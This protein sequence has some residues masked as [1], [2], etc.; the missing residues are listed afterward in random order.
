VEKSKLAGIAGGIV[1]VIIALLLIQYQSTTTPTQSVSKPTETKIKIIAS[2]YPLY[3]FATN[4]G[5]DKAKI[6]SFVPIGIEPHD[7]EPSTG[8][9]L[10]LKNTQLFVYNGAGMEP[11]VE[12]LINSEEYTNVKFVETAKGITLIESDN[13]HEDDDTHKSL[14]NPH[15]WLDPIL[16]KH[17]V[18]IIKDAIIESD[19]Q[20]KQ[21]YEDNANRY[22][23]KLENLDLKIKS[24]LSNCKKDTFV[25]FHDAYTY[26]ANRYGLSVFP[27]SGVSPESEATA[28]ELKQF[29]DFIK[30]NQIKVIYSEELIDPKLAQTLANEAG[31]QVLTFSPIEGLTNEELQNSMTYIQKMEQN[32]ENLKVGLE[33]Q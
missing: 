26:F 27:L 33:C 29:V 24:Q 11:F 13:D 23:T 7:W 16:A 22:L 4:V 2:F 28:A 19:P 14:Y 3:E 1:V 25:P 8:N 10:E 6:S 5:G 17:Q 9:I 20:N 12:K 31:A 30:E 15:I 18:T 32:L 21:Y